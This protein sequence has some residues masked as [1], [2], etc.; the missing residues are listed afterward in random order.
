MENF[1]LTINRLKCDVK[2]LKIKIWAYEFVESKADPL[3][4]DDNELLI[5]IGDEIV[6][7]IRF[8]WENCDEDMINEKACEIW[9]ANLN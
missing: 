7:N 2:E 6:K 3:L 4:I 8:M 9:N 1:H 5:K